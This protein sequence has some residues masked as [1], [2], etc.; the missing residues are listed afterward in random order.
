MQGRGTV[1]Q[2]GR[3]R[4]EGGKYICAGSGAVVCVWIGGRSTSLVAGVEET[5]RSFS[6]RGL[7]QL[8]GLERCLFGDGDATA[9]PW[10]R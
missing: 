5:G 1:E 6:G 10:R 8:C 9:G 3:N 2:Q 7:R 4:L